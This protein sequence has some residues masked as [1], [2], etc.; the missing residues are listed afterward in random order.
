M[1]L[2]KAS[3]GVDKRRQLSLKTRNMVEESHLNSF[4]ALHLVGEEA[5]YPV[6]EVEEG[7][8]NI[9]CR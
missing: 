7:Q 4:V 5:V 8:P 3:P 9:Q 1:L 2:W 6:P